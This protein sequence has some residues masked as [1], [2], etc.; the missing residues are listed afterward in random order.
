VVE[1]GCKIDCI[2]RARL[3]RFMN[4]NCGFVSGLIEAMKRF[5][6]TGLAM[7]IITAAGVKH[8]ALVS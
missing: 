4:S 2:I 3:Y 5:T 8:S 6:Q 1:I 7:H